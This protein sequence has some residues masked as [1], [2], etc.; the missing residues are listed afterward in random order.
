MKCIR[1][2]GC[3]SVD[4]LQRLHFGSEQEVAI[5]VSVI[6]RLYSKTI[7][8]QIQLSSLGIPNSHCEHPIQ[9]LKSCDTISIKKTQYHL[10]IRFR[11]KMVILGLEITPQFR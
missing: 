4:C 1:V 2:D 9:S 11:K 3:D 6:Q 5:R 8:C 7:P 10:G